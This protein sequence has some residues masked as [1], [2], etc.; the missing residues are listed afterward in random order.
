[1]SAK[2]TLCDCSLQ[3]IFRKSKLFFVCFKIICTACRTIL[4]QRALCSPDASILDTHNMCVTCVKT[5]R[6]LWCSSVCSKKGVKSTFETSLA[7]LIHTFFEQT[8]KLHSLLGNIVRMLHTRCGYLK[9]SPR[10]GEHSALWIRTV[11]HAMHIIFGKVLTPTVWTPV[12]KVCFKRPPAGRRPFKAN[13]SFC[14]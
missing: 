7:C 13:F 12:L 11:R 2:P 6:G 3:Q 14:F 1:M 4:I 9:H 8:L 5:P 10:S